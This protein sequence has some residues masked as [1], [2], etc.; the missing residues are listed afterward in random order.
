MSKQD[1]KMAYRFFKPGYCEHQSN[2]LMDGKTR[3]A[4]LLDKNF[5]THPKVTLLAE[6]S[7][8]VPILVLLHIW[9]RLEL[10]SGAWDMRTDIFDHWVRRTYNK[11][12]RYSVK[13]CLDALKEVDLLDFEIIPLAECLAYDYEN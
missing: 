6:K 8:P 4:I 11:S 3:K 1:V 9:G 13:G 7:D 12:N 10:E 2:R 5:S